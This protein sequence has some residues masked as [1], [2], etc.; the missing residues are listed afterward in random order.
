MLFFQFDFEFDSEPVIMIF[1]YGHALWVEDDFLSFFYIGDTDGF[2]GEWVDKDHE[3]IG[4][5]QDP[6]WD[7]AGPSEIRAIGLAIRADGFFFRWFGDTQSSGL[8]GVSAVD[9]TAIGVVE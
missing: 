1:G 5:S 3:V 7:P 4:T 9:P 6:A 2:K 8:I